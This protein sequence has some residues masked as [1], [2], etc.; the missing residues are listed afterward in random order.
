[1]AIQVNMDK[2][3]Q[4]LRKTKVRILQPSMESLDVMQQRDVRESSAASSGHGD[5]T[6]K[7]YGIK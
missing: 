7:R 5:N 3:L 4:D 1:M 6:S 2:D